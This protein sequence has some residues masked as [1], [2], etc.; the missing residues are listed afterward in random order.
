MAEH[1]FEQSDNRDQHN[2]LDQHQSFAFYL[3]FLSKL[4]CNQLCHF[5]EV[6]AHYNQTQSGF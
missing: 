3:K 2:N 4:Y 5:L 6:R 1:G